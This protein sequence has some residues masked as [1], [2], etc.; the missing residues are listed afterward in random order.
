MDVFLFFLQS[1][2]GA[3]T[4]GEYTQRKDVIIV[5]KINNEETEQRIMNRLQRV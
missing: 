2:V 5:R 4:N 3:Y 1:L